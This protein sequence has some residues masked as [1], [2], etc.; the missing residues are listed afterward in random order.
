MLILSIVSLGIDSLVL[1]FHALFSSLLLINPMIP[2]LDP[3]SR[4][5]TSFEFHQLPQ[6]E[7]V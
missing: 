7:C 3:L 2:T 6:K 5:I 4:H 1:P